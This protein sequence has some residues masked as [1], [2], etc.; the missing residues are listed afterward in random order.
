MKSWQNNSTFEAIILHA[1]YVRDLLLK[2]VS[3]L[4]VEVHLL[5]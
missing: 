3:M 4:R 5:R 2:G 1:L